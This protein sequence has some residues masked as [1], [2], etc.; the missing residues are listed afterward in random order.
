MKNT[1][2]CPRCKGEGIIKYYAHVR[3]GVC[4]KCEGSGEVKDSEND[5]TH[6]S[7]EP[8]IYIPDNPQHYA[9]EFNHNCY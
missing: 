9:S 1:K 8:S 6:W 7:D 5:G 4:F 3:G 2:K